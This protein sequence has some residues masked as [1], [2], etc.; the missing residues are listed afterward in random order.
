[1]N[2]SKK[3]NQ[4]VGLLKYKIQDGVIDGISFEE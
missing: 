4:S 1:M 2:L 3:S